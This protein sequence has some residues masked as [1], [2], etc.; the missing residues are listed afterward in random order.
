MDNHGQRSRNEASGPG[1]I[2]APWRIQYVA[3]AE[4]T[5][6]CIFCEKPSQERD[7][8]NLIILRGEHAFAILNRFPYNNGHLMVVPYRHTADFGSITPEEAAEMTDMLQRC[9]RATDELMHAH[10]YNIGLN[11]GSAAGAGIGDHLH[12]HLVPR[13]NG[14]TNFMAVTSNTRVISEALD[15]TWERLSARLN[16]R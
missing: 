12:Y 4:R 3:A 16:G 9:Q 11:L 8:D 2:W 15:E 7:R 5:E 1:I 6:G 14:D 10:G 13:W